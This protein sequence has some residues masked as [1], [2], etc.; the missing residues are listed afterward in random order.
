MMSHL[1]ACRSRTYDRSSAI[2]QCTLSSVLFGCSRQPASEWSKLRIF[3]F[4]SCSSVEVEIVCRSASRLLMAPGSLSIG[5]RR[6]CGKRAKKSISS[7]VAKKS[8]CMSMQQSFEKAF[9][10]CGEE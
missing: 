3:I 7:W 9:R 10:S 1:P 4:V 2:A 5:Q 8:A 6:S